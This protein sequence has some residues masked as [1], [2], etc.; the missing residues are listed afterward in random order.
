MVL[1]KENQYFRDWAAPSAQKKEK[2]LE[3]KNKT[4]VGPIWEQFWKGFG[5][6]KWAIKPKKDEPIFVLIWDVF[7]AT[8]GMDFKGQNKENIEV[9][10][11][12]HRSRKKMDFWTPRDL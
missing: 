5:C 7:W 3:P 6:P 8:I 4:L 1:Q 11:Y 9:N 12:Q 10:L 2:I